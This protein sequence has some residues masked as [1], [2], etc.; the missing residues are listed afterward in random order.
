MIL[1]YLFTEAMERLH[2]G[3]SNGLRRQMLLLVKRTFSTYVP[4]TSV[5][6]VNEVGIPS[7]A[8]FQHLQHHMGT[9]LLSYGILKIMSTEPDLNQRPRD[10]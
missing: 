6:V 9:F 5:K 3:V 4:L 2:G 7:N 1:N 8:V 10:I